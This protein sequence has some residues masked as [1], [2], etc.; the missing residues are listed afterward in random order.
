[1]KLARLA[2]GC[3]ECEQTGIGGEPSTP[4][5]GELRRR[6]IAVQGSVGVPD[7]FVPDCESVFGCDPAGTSTSYDNRFHDNVMGRTPA[8]KRRPN[9]IDFWWDDVSGQT[10][11]CWFDNAGARGGE[12]SVTYDPIDIPTHASECASADG[13]QAPFEGP[14]Q[15]ELI[16]CLLPSGSQPRPETILPLAMIGPEVC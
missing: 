14:Q 16:G 8:G 5:V 9:G 11:N 13:H 1:M 6:A 7:S 3:A 12:A 15:Q 2:G 10:G 4:S